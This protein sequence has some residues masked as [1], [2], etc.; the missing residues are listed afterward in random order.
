M[1][2]KRERSDLLKIMELT[3][4]ANLPVQDSHNSCRDVPSADRRPQGAVWVTYD[5]LANVE[6]KAES[7]RYFVWNWNRW[8]YKTFPLYCNQEFTLEPIRQ[9]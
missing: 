6:S 4:T 9:H 2:G 8:S 3:L 5:Q 1:K 7:L